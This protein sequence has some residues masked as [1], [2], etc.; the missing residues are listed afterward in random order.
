MSLFVG[1][2]HKKRGIKD[3]YIM[4]L[5]EYC[6]TEELLTLANIKIMMIR[7]LEH[8]HGHFC[9]QQPPLFEI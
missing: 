6:A 1:P 2:R 3:Y 8:M 9:K 7:I 5:L 4:Y